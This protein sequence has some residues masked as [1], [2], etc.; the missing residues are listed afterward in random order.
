MNLPFLL[1]DGTILLNMNA[2]QQAAS[3]P[4]EPS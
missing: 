4:V 2:A 1:E 3:A